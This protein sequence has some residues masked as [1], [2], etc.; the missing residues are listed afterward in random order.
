MQKYTIRRG[1]Y[2]ESTVELWAVSC[3]SNKEVRAGAVRTQHRSGAA[4]D[5]LTGVS[6]L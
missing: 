2:L 4:F 5:Q 6:P 1:H 3:L